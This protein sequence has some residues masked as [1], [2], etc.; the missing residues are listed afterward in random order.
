V[1][2]LHHRWAQELLQRPAPIPPRD[3]MDRA[4]GAHQDAAER[5]RNA[6][7]P[8]THGP[9]GPADTLT[10]AGVMAASYQA[11]ANYCHDKRCGLGSLH[12]NGRHR[13]LPFPSPG[14]PTSPALTVAQCQL[15]AQHL[16]KEVRV[17]ADSNGVAMSKFA[18][19]TFT[20]PT[21]ES[22][23]ILRTAFSIPRRA[24]IDLRPQRPA[25]PSR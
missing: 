17:Q 24:P 13:S 7:D 11:V 18:L 1:G 19:D 4:G 22:F 14:D 20:S 21:G 16:A 23:R 15:R 6:P 2:D 5:P 3:R 12:D 25:W 9:R 10:H 8:I